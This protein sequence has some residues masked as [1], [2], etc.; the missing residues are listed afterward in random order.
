MGSR[1]E[2]DDRAIR[3]ALLRATFDPASHAMPGNAFA[4]RSR[5]L[6][7][8]VLSLLEGARDESLGKSR[9]S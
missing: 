3:I 2:P 8:L 9:N 5:A 7:D 4:A 1:F 6:L